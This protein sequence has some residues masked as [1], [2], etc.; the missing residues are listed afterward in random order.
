[1]DSNMPIAII[2]MSCRFAGDVDSPSKLWDLLAQGKSAWSEIPKDRFNIDGFHHPNFEKLNGTNVIGGH[3]MK[4]DVGLFD[5]HFF[6]LSAETAAALD[7][8]FRLQLESTY[9]A[10][11]SAGITLQDVA[12]S[13]TSVYAGSFFRDYHES[14]IRDPDTLPRF[15]LMGTGAA[16]ASNRLSHFFDLRGPSM[17]VDTGCSTTLTALHQACQSLRSGESTMSIVGGANIMFNPDMFLAMSSMTLI[18]KDGRSWAFDSR[19]NGYGRGEG[20]ATVVLKPLDAALR[21]GDPIRAV[22][23]DSGINQD[24]K[25]ETITTPSG[26]AQE[27]L[28][29]ACYERAGLDPGQTTYFEA[30]GTGT[31]T[32]DPIEVKAIA[33]VFKDSRKGNG[34]DALLRIGSVKT[35]IGHT[36]TASGVAAIIKVAL[37]LE[38]G[39]IPPSINFETPNAKLS[40]DEWKLK[41]P[42]ELEEW[43][44]K[45]G[46]RRASINNFGYGGSNAHVIM[47]DYS[48]YLATTQ[49]PKALP[50][51]N[52]TAPG[53][54]HHHHHQHT[55]SG[56]VIDDDFHGNGNNGDHH[57][58]K[59]FLLSA[60]DEKATE[61]MIANLK[62]YLHQQ[63]ANTH[64][65][66][67]ENALL[68]N[69]AHT[70]CD[71]RT[72][73]PWTATFS[74]ASLDSLIRTLD[75]GRVKPAKASA[76]PPRIGFVFTGQGAQWWAMG[77]E[78]I[79]AYPIFKAALL[80]CDVQLKKL[81]ATWNM[82]EELSRDAETSKVNQLDYSTPVC[83]AVQI[84]LVEL[85]KAWGIKPTAVTSHSSG[86]IAA[87]YAAGALDLASAMAIAFA[88][89]GLAS[90][91]NRQ[92]ARKGGMM[93][94][95]LGRE[96]AEKYL[97]R[98]TQGQVVVA[99][100]NS[101]TSSTLSG[102]VE[103]LVELEQIMKEENIFARRLKVDAAW[104]SHHM[105]AVADAYYASM[106]KKVK[107]A[108][109]KLDMIFSSP[110]TGKRMD[111]V[112]EIGSPGHW[113]RSLT[114]CVRFVDAFRSMVF[115]EEG[116]TEPTVDMVIEVG[117]HAA[118]SGPIQD[119]L[120][121]PQF[122]G[123]TIPYGSCLIR[124]KSAVDTM[125]D[126]VGDLV[127]K[128]YPVNLKAVNFPFGMEGVKVLTDLP[129]YPWNHS[130]KHWIEP[131]F[132]RAL[133]Q[134]SEAPHDLLGSLVLGCDPSAPTWRH[135]VRL[136]DLPWAKD[137]CVQG[138]MIYPAAGYIAM[139]VEGMQRFA[140]RQAGDKKI[141]GYQLRDVDILNALVVPETSEGIEMQL[142]LR[143]GS[144]R[145]LS[146][147]GW[148][149]FTVQ[150]V[151][152]D[153]K[154][155]DHC[156]GLIWV[157]FGAAPKH[158]VNQPTQDSH[159]R[160]R[161]N[162]ND[163]W[164]GMR[165][166]GINHGPIFRNM[167][168]IRARSKQSVTTFTVADT[169]SVMPKQHEHAHVIHP[170]TL[171]SV[172]QAAYTAAPGA[173]GKN[174]TPKVPRSISKL[175]IS[176]DISKQAGHD[177]KA[178]A[179][180]DH[181]DDQ[182]TK[183][184]LRVV[185][186]AADAAAP[187]IS[188]DGFVCQSIGNAPTAADEPWE[189]DKFTTTHWAPDVTFLK[190]AFLKKQLGSQITPEE[191][192]ILMDLRKA[193]MYYIYDA[194]R[195]LTPEDIKK[196]EWYHKKF[197]IW[198]RLQ[199]DLA[200][201]NELGPDSSKWA[202]AT[203]NEK[204]ILLEK[205]KMS[206]T[207]GEM[208]YRLGPQIVPILRG[209]ITAL[210]VMLEQNLLS[211]YYLE[212]LKWGRANAKLGEMV[213]H[214]AHKNPHA[215]MIEIGGGTGGAT[216]HVLNAIGTADDGLGPRAASYDF[217]DVSSGFF[218]AAKEKFQPWKDL[219]RFKKL[220][221]EQ[222]PVSQGFEEGT[223]DVVIAC[224]VLHAT[225]SMDNTMQNV[226]K[227]LKPGGKLFIMETTQDQMDVQFVFGFLSGWWLSEEEERKFSPSLSVP[228]W[229][230]VL[231]RTGFR[232]VEAEIRDVEHDELYAF[233]VMSSTAA[234]SA[235]V[236]DF[237]ITF[238]TASN[239]IPEVW[240]DKLRV[241]IGLL[242]CSVPTVKSLEEVTVDG[243][244]V[245]V[246]LDDPKNPVLADPSKAQFSGVRDMCTRAKGLL[247]LTQGGADECDQPL[248]SLAAGFL[249]SLRQ[250]Y[251][252][253]RLA[254]LDLDPIQ[255]M[256]SET[257]IT[258]ITEVFRKLFDYSINE[259][260]SD[261]EFAER[262]GAVK[263]P[264]YIK[265]VT[266]N[267]AVF[268]QQQATTQPEAEMQP[269]IQ[270][271]RPLRLAIGTAGLLDT[272]KFV[273]DPT[274]S[275]PLPE[276]FV[277]VEPRAFGVNFR[278]VMVA[279]GQLKSNT[280]GYDC[281][282]VITRVGPAAA[283]EGYQV[284]DRV[285]V[286]L[287]GHY[288]S[289]TRIH[290]TSAVK[291][292]DTM[293]FET[294]AS[295]PTQYVAAYVSLYDTARL[296]KGESVLI[297]AATGG[298]G[299]AA[300]MMAQRVGA[301]VFVTVGTDEKREFV[302]KHYGIAADHIFSS[303][304]TSFAAGVMAMTKGRG[305]DVVLNSLAGTLLQ[306]SFNCLA[307]FGRFVEIGKR[308][309][310]QNSSLAME[311]FTRAVS[312]TSI[313]VITLGE[314][315]KMET[316]RIMKD[317][318]HLVGAGELRVVEPITVYPVG[319]IEKA[320]RLMQAGKHMGK[321][322]LTASEETLV[323][324]LPRA[325]SNTV[326]LRSDASYLV[327]G[328]FGGLGRSICSWLAE[329]GAKNLVIVS[330]NAKADKLAQLQT[331]LNHV[332][333]GVK[334]TAISCDI[335]NMAVLTKALDCVERGVPPIRGIIHGGM[336]LRDSVLEHM[337]LEDHKAALA[338]K[339]NG[340]WNLH[341]YFSSTEKESLDF[342]IM[343]SSLVGV[344][345][346]ASQSNYSAG[347][348][349]QDSLAT[350]RVAH[351]LP[352]V[353]LDLP[354]VKSVG[355]L[356]DHPDSEKT[357][358]SLKR[359]GFTALAEDEV[360]AAI[361]SAIQTPFAGPL[362]LGLNCGPSGQPSL[363]A[364]LA[365]DARFAQLKHRAVK[366]SSTSQSSVSATTGDLSSLLASSQSIEEAV[367]HTLEAISKKLQDI[368][369]IA[370]ASEINPDCS[371]AEFGVDSLVA[372][373]L[374][375]MLSMKAGSEMSIF[376]IMQCGSL[377]GLAG[378]VVG[379]SG[380][381]DDGLKE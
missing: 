116:A 89:G 122:K 356:A 289:R 22:I 9:E 193:C 233:S 12:G 46:I 81:G 65:K 331:E 350:H 125:Q 120:G 325:T 16:M 77:K 165:S 238:V 183:T 50:L 336:E 161:I 157:Q 361:G 347:G 96:E 373:E 349:F 258:T 102:D 177:F 275:D 282:G 244:D 239:Q 162:P 259:A 297:H 106:D 320:F 52:G 374:R 305:V 232:G 179:N 204:A 202:N 18:S 74:G 286:L 255:D 184:A 149:E 181:A 78:L 319:E 85:L 128:G 155:T 214:Y 166:G 300:V 140:S 225:K 172:F 322:V 25:T 49:R 287:R 138:N 58:S 19:A 273:D 278:D 35:N 326:S 324:V 208:V 368:F 112:N 38:R 243:N 57:H 353:S 109:S 30:H 309:L 152:L 251:S 132:N 301:E 150:S 198:M 342:Y 219:M 73:F 226:R 335:S 341:Q 257:S 68:S 371:P 59:V 194:L 261:Y 339:L 185:D 256:W 171:D 200:R 363:D 328:G 42:T 252:G 36:E 249:R 264:R 142:S 144:E 323:P 285:S 23:R 90:E 93:A 137:H 29:R 164:A 343:L 310:E 175:W 163:I 127:R 121:M 75:S 250:E 279:M 61:R 4:E 197:Y 224:Q 367:T 352:G 253:K 362:T 180:L 245:C 312:Y 216:A 33:R 53:H 44:G 72:L 380:F 39:Q 311:A 376:E 32:G 139:A 135:I 113:V 47:E 317:I 86:E 318:I 133:R 15:L 223:Y 176:H 26:E 115:A 147:K 299:Q 60:K 265:D 262:E 327:V 207:N 21:D 260:G 40:L 333:K 215:K 211:R 267:S 246:F 87:A 247:W 55:D 228:M 254:T 70:L 173:G 100:E 136:G 145:D 209:E 13:N 17:S 63:K 340:S 276:D 83:V 118:L 338:P 168:S 307:P 221:I 88:R 321:I 316:N 291:I 154:W 337:K 222:D 188:I 108:K 111:K 69:L 212:G 375:N 237:D 269:F 91:G 290:W 98:V 248:A 31:P 263:I 79:D 103:G 364:P 94:V 131:R 51:T 105:E 151:N 196:L 231:H 296:Q 24:G 218:E 11:E 230:R 293:T 206:S 303:R 148:T 314:Y 354:V 213:R 64:S 288:A 7:P 358:D 235:P 377:K 10:L 119:I 67:A 313:D 167:K 95:G 283:A 351:G 56:I 43:V 346:F 84:A 1:M 369:M 266:R 272:L 62:T 306:E 134:R 192:E 141:A 126:L 174:Q 189:A 37:A 379:K 97:P 372:V 220:N 20:S 357:I 236:F 270:P 229:D 370:D 227:L 178:Y 124:K 281:A 381:V 315:K 292:P 241:S 344:V 5:A 170:T 82:C 117:P 308:D 304:D 99:C 129:A 274:A 191:A 71:R 114:G 201:A 182:S 205:V 378:V 28:I 76:Q 104:H 277:E 2:G 143:P 8:Q 54:H 217:T 80:D 355:Y 298:V 330:R 271:D 159:Y 366:S 153:N 14:L 329:H 110:C 345:G 66:I 334:V 27:A 195:D 41:V 3:F 101:P 360:L 160:I 240:L 199:A 45:D 365:R 130:T 6:N 190:D 284:G 123:V 187:V 268:K 146:T 332:S 234:A 295:L 348:T 210:E 203:L 158:A 107:P 169:K 302:M 156:K 359:H 280:M 48:S 186:D 92:F 294:A 242:T 34:E